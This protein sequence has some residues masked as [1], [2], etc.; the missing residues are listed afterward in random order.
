MQQSL[1]SE[2]SLHHGHQ[3]EQHQKAKN[4]LMDV[5]DKS[6]VIIYKIIASD[7]DQTEMDQ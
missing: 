5:S 7:D 2:N 1:S 3:S 4:L 6:N